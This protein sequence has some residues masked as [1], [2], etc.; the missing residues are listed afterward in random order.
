MP[1]SI[2]PHTNEHSPHHELGNVAIIAGQ[3]NLP[4]AVLNYCQ[5]HHINTSFIM[6]EGQVNKN[7]LNQN[8]DPSK[9]C[10][11]K[12]GALSPVLNFLTQNNIKTLVLAGS[13]KRPSL[14]ELS[15]DKDGLSMIKAIGVHFVKGDNQLLEAVIKQLEKLGYQL[16]P[17]HAFIQNAFL[18]PG[19]YG[20]ADSNYTGD[21]EIG[22]NILNAL[23]RYDIGQ[24][25][26]IDNERIYGIEGI[27]GTSNLIQRLKK[28]KDPSSSA[29]V[30]PPPTRSGGL[31]KM[32]KKAQTMTA[33]VP[34]IGPDTIEQLYQAY[35]SW[36]AIEANSVQVLAQDEVFQKLHAYQMT[37]IAF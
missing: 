25:L 22:I 1:H 9:I 21:I 6:F 11:N 28:C 13:I 32:A 14:N 35:Y 23:S 4:I 24:A 34:T 5:Q 18:A 20:N 19:I 15:L 29:V 27:E 7:I 3:G 17:A 37:L 12:L 26:I 16:K 8:I 33:D 2:P 31:I 10:I 30:A 36:I